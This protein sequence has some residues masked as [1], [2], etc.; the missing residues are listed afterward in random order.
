[1]SRSIPSLLLSLLTFTALNPLAISYSAFAQSNSTA[2][3]NPDES[4]QSK[5]AILADQARSAIDRQNGEEAF[6]ALQQALPIAL[7]LKN[8]PFQ[9]DLVQVWLVEAYNGFPTTRFIQLTEQIKAPQRSL[10]LLNQF[11]TLTNRLPASNSSEKTLATVAIAR[12]Y[13]ALGQPQT[14]SRLIA[15]SRQTEQLIKD[16]QLRAT[17]LIEIAEAYAELQQGQAAQTTLAQVE[18]AVQLVTDEYS[19]FKIIERAAI[20]YA[21]LGNYP[22]A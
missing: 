15:R 10:S 7:Q 18:K 5:L 4:L 16:P 14:A 3:C 20:L 12:Q 8:A 11:L 1:M 13:N 6:T 19:R 2:V 22:K 9:A 21:R 17:A